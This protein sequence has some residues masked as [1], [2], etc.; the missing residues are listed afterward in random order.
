MPGGAADDAAAGG[1]VAGGEQEISSLSAAVQRAVDAAGPGGGGLVQRVAARLF[2]D[3][4]QGTIAKFLDNN[5]CHFAD[6]TP[7]HIAS[8]E[9]QLAWWSSYERFMALFDTS[10]EEVV[11]AE[12]ATPAEF[13]ALAADEASLT[14]DERCVI[15]LLH[16]SSDYKAF[17]ELMYDE[18]EE[19]R[20]AL[21]EA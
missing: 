21:G 18:V 4:L 7:A 9:N 3:E 19:K 12:G 11:A 8:G 16:A 20:E 10:L 14:E 1:G 6:L 5:A 15:A 2:S 17:L 13:A